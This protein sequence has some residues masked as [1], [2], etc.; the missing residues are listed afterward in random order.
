M[1]IL[2][3]GNLMTVKYYNPINK[4]F[5]FDVIVPQLEKLRERYSPKFCEIV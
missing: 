1:I 5:N 4:K 2:E 3:I